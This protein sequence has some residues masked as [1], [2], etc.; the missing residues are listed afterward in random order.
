[1]NVC[2]LGALTIDDGRVP[3]APRDRTVLAALVARVGA[4]VSVESLTRALWGDEAPASWS[5]IVA[6]CIVRLR[7]VIKPARIET[8]PLGYR[9]VPGDLDIDAESFEQQVARGTELLDL[10]EPDRAAHAISHALGLWRGQAFVELSDWEPAR[11]L[12]DRLEERRL[13]AE[14]LLLKAMLATGD[15]QEAAALAR[16]R[17]AEAPFREHRW[18]ILAL[19]QYRQ[20]RQSEALATVRRGRALL[21]AELGLDPCA[22]LAA[23]EQ[24]VLT[25]DPAL[26][27]GSVLH[28]PS[29]D[30]P[31]FGLAPAGIEDAEDYF[32]REVE[33]A[34]GLRALDE[35]GVIVVAGPS[36]VGKSSYVR[37]GL[38]AQLTARGR[39]VIVVTPGAHPVRTLDALPPMRSTDVLVV[40]QCEQALVSCADEEERSAFFRRLVEQLFRGPLIVA[41]RADRLGDL[42][43]HAEFSGV[44][45]SHVTMLGPLSEEGMRAAIEEPARRAGLLLEPGLVDLLLRE[46]HGG[47]LPLV[48]HSLRQTWLRREGRTLTV[49]GY[50]ESG[51][52]EGSVART[53]EQLYVGLS[54]HDQKLVREILLRLIESSP[55]VPL[56]ARS[57]PRDRVVLD[58]AHARVLGQLV[59]ERLLTTDDGSV[60][61]S[62]EALT[63]A[64]PRLA[65]WLEEDVDG[66]RIL[67]HLATAATAWDGMSR[68]DSEL[69]RGARLSAALEW[70][71][72]ADIALTPVESDF[73]AASS[74]QEVESLADAQRRLTSE[75]RTVRRLRW[76]SS[77]VAVLAV[78]SLAAGGV[79]AV[80]AGVADERATVAEARRVAALA[81]GEPAFDRALLLALEAIRISDATETRRELLRVLE[82][83]PLAV[84]IVRAPDDVRLTQLSAT[85][86]GELAT[87]IDSEEDVAVFDVAEGLRVL[88]LSEEGTSFLASELAPSG[89]R[90]AVSWANSECWDDDCT[91]VGLRILDVTEDATRMPRMADAAAPGTRYTGFPYPIA[92]IAFSP[93]GSLVAAI[94]PVPWYRAP[95]NIAVWKVADPSHPILLGLEEVGSNPT[96]TPELQVF[97]TVEFSPDGTQLLASGFGPI[98]VFDVATARPIA[99]IDGS[100]LLA[101]SADGRTIAVSQGVNG[102]RVIDLDD[103]D[104]SGSTLSHTASV[105]AA[106]FSPDG[107]ELATAS[108]NG[109]AT[110]WDARAGRQVHALRAHTGAVNGVAFR[111]DGRLLTAG[112]DGTIIEWQPDGDFAAIRGSSAGA[113]SLEERTLAI[114]QPDGSAA[115]V[116]GSP[117]AWAEHACDLAG[118]ALTREEW[119]D[120]FGETRYE[121]ACR[122]PSDAVRPG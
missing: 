114:E 80:Q 113:E 105:M 52:I 47:A 102:V 98:S 112:A 36:G 55:G 11:I 5:K 120:V 72:S 68:P 101:A 46:A 88:G 37:A 90:V 6:G 92:D 17:V 45:R 106:A 62:H 4:A 107:S 93:D 79:A 103:P 74:A 82:R 18:A 116:V 67:S 117:S 39:E 10:G 86:Q 1:M 50:R 111:S 95:G 121:P 35:H 19:A 97:G 26:L 83:G 16:A 87:T 65:A 9:L 20:G 41:I 96:I 22:E 119:A 63:R 91:E 2:V 34:E 84:G 89:D 61:L 60:E 43:L 66:Q 108:S 110:I 115:L 53:A 42:A 44:L 109:V 38:G 12:S 73:L 59:E 64:W 58:E 40:D 99:R 14:E 29:T 100:G 13:G 122:G 51:G 78:A 76:L 57:V 71:D 23:L 27:S 24:A 33:V 3:L 104:A 30:C 21:A 32:G 49:D 118:R 69:Y 31:Y 56:V 54:A 28:A 81:R 25:Q 8:T 7:K 77:A 70:R 75:R 85:P 15:L 48:S 94:A